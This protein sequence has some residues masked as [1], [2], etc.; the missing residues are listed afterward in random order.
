MIQYAFV[1]ILILVVFFIYNAKAEQVYDP[2]RRFILNQPINNPEASEMPSVPLRHQIK[3]PSV[4]FVPKEIDYVTF[5]DSNKRH[6]Y[7]KKKN[8]KG[9]TNADIALEATLLGRN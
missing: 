3:A 5:E 9:M 2:N 8:S 6:L 4:S 1:V 7:D